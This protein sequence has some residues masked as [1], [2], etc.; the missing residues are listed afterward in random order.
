MRTLVDIDEK[1]LAALDDI[2][3]RQRVSRA[4]LIR[5]AVSDLLL[6]RQGPADEAAFGLWAEKKV[7][8][9]AYQKALRQEW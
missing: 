2:A 4:S 5:E 1:A 8:G 3:R 6:K 7:D 9:L